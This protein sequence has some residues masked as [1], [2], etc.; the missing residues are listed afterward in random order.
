MKTYLNL[1]C[2]TRF[3]PE[4]TNVDFVGSD[5]SILSHN[6]LTGIPFPDETFDV[7]YHSHLLEH[8]PKSAALAFI[9]E[10]YR[11]LKPEGIHRIAVPDL[12]RI[13]RVYLEAL[14]KA[15]EGN[16]RWADNYEWMTLEILD[17]LVREQGGGEMRAY[18]LNPK[19]S[20]REFVLARIG[21]EA[22]NL[23][24]RSEA[25]V[26]GASD[27]KATALNL[28]RIRRGLR[29]APARLRE[30]ILRLVLGN[31]YE[32]LKLA[33]F[34]RGGEVH[35][36]MYDRY[37]LSKLLLTA[38]FRSPQVVTASESRIPGWSN[39]HMDTEPDGTI[40]KPDSLFVEATR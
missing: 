5:T 15:A 27:R 17:Q 8:L 7:V 28:R 39:Y 14:E 21:L 34:R 6:L 1:G 40:Y 2:G 32:M 19:L 18:L 20:N 13:A 35:L 22:Q 30:V 38:G 10:C 36:W 9:K 33:R 12:E 23:M 4:W 24:N 26:S 31:D 29:H 11:V 3:H 25:A 16:E 37:S